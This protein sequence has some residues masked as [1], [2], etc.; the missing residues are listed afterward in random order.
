MIAQMVRDL[1]KKKCALKISG[2]DESQHFPVEL[3]RKMGE[4]G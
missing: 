4:L 2:V 3:F 1:A